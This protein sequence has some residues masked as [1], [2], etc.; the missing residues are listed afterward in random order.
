MKKLLWIVLA[1]VVLGGSYAAYQFY[2]PH[3]DIVGEK[4]K[5]ELG[6]ADLVA[7]YMDDE[8]SANAVYLD[9]VVAITGIVSESDASHVKLESGVYC[10]GNFSEASLKEGDKV[11]VK[12]RVVGYDELFEEVT[13]DNTV[14]QD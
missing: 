14:V 6:A 13:L 11:S 2:K 5:H 8:Q 10:N 12:G 9:Q 3:R 1:I 4:A 7:K